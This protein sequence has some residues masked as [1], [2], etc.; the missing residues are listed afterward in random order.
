MR[1]KSVLP[2]FRTERRVTARPAGPSPGATA[3][4]RA[5][6]A[7]IGFSTS[8]DSAHLLTAFTTAKAIVMV[9]HGLAGDD[10]GSSKSSPDDQ[11][12]L[13]VPLH[14]H[15]RSHTYPISPLPHP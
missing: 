13:V 1:R 14:R 5:G 8:C 11:H 7:L 10:R 15:P 12:C 2:R 3:Q 4:G 9:T 6:D